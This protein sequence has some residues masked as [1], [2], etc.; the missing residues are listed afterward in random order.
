MKKN[1]RND[2]L[3]TSGSIN[4]P[5]G[6]II[7][8]K[9]YLHVANILI[10]KLEQKEYHIELLSMPFDHSFGLVRLRC[11]ILAGTQMFV[12]DGLKNF[13]EIF[14]FSLEKCLSGISLVPSGLSLI[15]FLLKDKVKLFAK[16][17][18]YLELGSSH[19]NR[20]LR[21][22]L[23]KNFTKTI[24]IHHYG[25]TEA[26]RSFLIYRG[27]DDDLKKNN[28]MIG[29]IIS[30]CKYKIDSKNNELLLKGKNLFEGYVD[31]KDDQ[32]RFIGGWYRTGDIVKRKNNNLYLI[33]RLDNQFNIGGNKVQAE[34]IEN[35]IE[36]INNVKKSL[37][38]LQP[39]EIY[40]SALAL[41]IEKKS[42]A[43]EYN[44]LKNIKKKIIGFP[45]YYIPKK[46]IFRK[47]MLTKNGKKIRIQ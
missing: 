13:P 37:C 35:I 44:I 22:W 2:I 27:I 25:M 42:S 9:A 12:S 46:I 10:K 6:V 47:I 16:N 39:D 19:I 41:I 45:D 15:K 24:I 20:E 28:N 17:L 34:F 32:N 11:C 23:K 38:F 21:Y 31:R 33:G 4:S 18:K 1:K 14:K 40:G 3:F 26:S 7:S 29:K 43:N 30:G 36:S 5:K 8:E